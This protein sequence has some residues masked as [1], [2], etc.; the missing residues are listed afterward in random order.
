ME[1]LRANEQAAEVA[2]QE[3][4]MKLISQELTK[5]T[6]R[7][8]EAA[9]KSEVMNSVLPALENITKTELKAAMGGNLT[10]SLSDAIKQ[11]RPV[12]GGRAGAS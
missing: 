9:V 6:T 5:N 4:L 1:D 3:K 7:V 2:R 10:K 12:A 8:V 11:V